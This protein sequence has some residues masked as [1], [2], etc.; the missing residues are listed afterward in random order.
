MSSREQQWSVRSAA[1]IGRAIGEIRRSHNLTQAELAS[2][3][4]MSRDSLAQLES[5][6]SG[7]ALEHVVRI[8][9]RM[10]AQVTIT[11]ENQHDESRHGEA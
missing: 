4:G 3:I 2:Q 6:R 1:D 10:G 5:G 9:R 11:V 8:L 7:R